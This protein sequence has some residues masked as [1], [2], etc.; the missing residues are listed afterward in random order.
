MFDLKFIALFKKWNKFL[1]TID[2]FFKDSNGRK[3]W[4]NRSD[5]IKY[6]KN[7][8][9]EGGLNRVLKT[10]SQDLTFEINYFLNMDNSVLFYHTYNLSHFNVINKFCPF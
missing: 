7:E 4:K 1:E 6:S 10:D 5:Y 3:L 9:V 2:L 8:V